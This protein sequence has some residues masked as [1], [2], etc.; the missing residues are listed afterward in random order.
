MRE[1]ISEAS[2]TVEDSQTAQAL[3]GLLSLKSPESSNNFNKAK[4]TK[5][6]FKG[7][8][9]LLQKKNPDF[10]IVSTFKA[11]K[12]KNDLSVKILTNPYQ[13]LTTTSLDM[14]TYSNNLPSSTNN[15]TN[16]SI[17]NSSTNEASLLNVLNIKPVNNAVNNAANKVKQDL[18]EKLLTLKLE[19][20][21][22]G[23]CSKQSSP[24][25]VLLHNSPPI[26]HKLFSQ[27][28]KAFS[29]LIC[30]IRTIE[31]NSVICLQY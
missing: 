2:K 31:Y 11:I 20:S 5:S 23:H 29:N 7:H 25:L 10:P 13:L 1:L 28:Q 27:I 4:L 24:S 21:S 8:Q 22:N 15:S 19:P 26:D 3:H 30:N 6:P 12:P 18:K 16:N 14:L 17:N 9:R